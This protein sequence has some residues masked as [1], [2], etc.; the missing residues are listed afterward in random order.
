MLIEKTIQ[1]KEQI[2][3]FIHLL[4]KSWSKDTC[5]PKI[6]NDWSSNNKSLG[7]CAVTSLIIND[8]FGGDIYKVKINGNSH[9]FNIINNEIIDLTKDQFQTKKIEYLNIEKKGRKEILQTK[10]TLE[11]Y[12]I[13]K[14]QINKHLIE[15]NNLN[16][17]IRQCKKC[18]KL[19]EKFNNSQ[20]IYFGNNTDLLLLGEAPA[21]NGWRKSKMIWRDEK[22]K[23]LPSAIIMQKLLQPLELDLFDLSFTEAIKC[24][25]TNR[26]HLN[27]CQNNC[28]QYL[29]KQ[30]NFLSPKII[31][32]LGNYATK[33]LL[34][35]K[36]KNFKEVV[37]QIFEINN[38]ENKIIVLP[39]YHPSPISPL[40][41]KGNIEI[42]KKLND[43]L[44]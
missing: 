35:I 36:Y 10:N 38:G 14:N 30:I 12:N 24:Y 1:N 40:S 29:Q 7:Q 32:T 25:P 9:Y 37:G 8:H 19:I 15:F 5:Y 23:L 16:N 31:I 43:L 3:F 20:V 28:N 6:K 11:R 33:S 41:Y 21:N 17:E 2:N 27:T 34:K 42:F 44:K 22:G 4:N 18:D 13:L 26:K 39:I